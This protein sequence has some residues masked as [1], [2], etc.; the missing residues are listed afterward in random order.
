MNWSDNN[1]HTSLTL[2]AEIQHLNVNI[3]ITEPETKGMQKW[4]AEIKV[5]FGSLFSQNY[6]PSLL[7]VS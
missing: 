6:V 7:Y 4:K 2:E 3:H 1:K 5:T